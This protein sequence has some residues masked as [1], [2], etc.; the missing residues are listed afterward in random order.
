MNCRTEHEERR[1]FDKLCRSRV[2]S[3]GT[4]GYRRMPCR[5][6]FDDHWHA[7]PRTKRYKRPRFNPVSRHEV[8]TIALRECRKNNVRLNQRELVADALSWPCAERK[9]HKFWPIGTALRQEA[10]GIERFRLRPE[11][12]KPMQDVRDDERQPSAR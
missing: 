3:L 10:V 9:V 2:S 11:C 1:G 4:V 7:E 5:P 12:G 6:T 8:K